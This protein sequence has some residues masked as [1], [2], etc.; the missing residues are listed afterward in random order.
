[1][2]GGDLWATV[3]G[4]AQSWTQLSEHNVMDAK[5]SLEI[6]IRNPKK[7]ATSLL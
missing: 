6:C 2:D 4:I 1:M 7:K 3:H 5:I